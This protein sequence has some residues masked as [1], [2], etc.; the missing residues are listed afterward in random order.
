MKEWLDHNDI[1]MSLTHNGG[2][3]WHFAA[4]RNISSK[5]FA[6]NLVC[7]V[8]PSPQILGK[9]QMGVFLISVFLVNPL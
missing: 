2:K 6:P 7:P 8:G 9:S 1:L 5:T 3:P 4:F